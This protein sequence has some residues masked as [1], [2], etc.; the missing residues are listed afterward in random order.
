MTLRQIIGTSALVLFSLA[1]TAVGHAATAAPDNNNQIIAWQNAPGD[2][3]DPGKVKLEYYGHMAFRITTPKGLTMLIDPWKNDPSGTWGV[4][5]PKEFPMTRADIAASTHAHYDHN[6]LHRVT[7]H[8]VL[9]RMAGQW[10][11]SDLRITGIADKHQYEAPGM[12][13]WTELFDERGIEHRPPNN[14][15]VLDNCIYVVETGGLRIVHWGDNRPDAPDAVYKAVGRPDILILPID[16]SV[17][18]LDSAQ[19]ASIIDRLRPHVVIPAHYLIKN[20]SSVA[21]TLHTA[22]KWVAAQP[23]KEQVPATLTV[24]ADQIR[25]HDRRVFYFGQNVVSGQ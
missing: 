2:P 25:K 23:S 13:R 22:D 17:H 8:M 12:V 14:P 4:W 3:A 1:A 5:F 6:A 21:S 24:T 19:A 10:T 16:D 11:L 9:D 20:V 7:S 15:P 18:V